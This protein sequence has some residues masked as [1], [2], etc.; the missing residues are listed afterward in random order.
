MILRN[1]APMLVET[2]REKGGLNQVM[3]LPLFRFLAPLPTMYWYGQSG[4][5]ILLTYLLVRN[6]C[7]KETRAQMLIEHN[8]Q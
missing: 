3:F 5:G 1:F 4:K 6:N 7:P 8:E 2:F